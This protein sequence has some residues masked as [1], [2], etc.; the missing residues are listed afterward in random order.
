MK[1]HQLSVAES[2][3]SV[4]SGRDGL[5]AAEAARRLVEFGP[6]HVE[7]LPREPHLKLF[8]K[9][10]THFFAMVLWLAAGLAFV[11]EWRQPSQ[12]MGTLGFAIIGG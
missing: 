12:G 2:F 11:A 10:F 5:A 9:G 8:L 7:Q 6:N 4:Q 1:I 3:A